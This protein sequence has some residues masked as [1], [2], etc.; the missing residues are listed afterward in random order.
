MTFSRAVRQ[1]MKWNRWKMRP[2]AS[3]LGRQLQGERLGPGGVDRGGAARIPPDLRRPLLAGHRGHEPDADGGGGRVVL[4][5]AARRVGERLPGLE[6]VRPQPL[7][8][9]DRR[10]AVG[11]GLPLRL[12][13]D[14]E[15]EAPPPLLGIA[16]LG[17]SL[18]NLGLATLSLVAAVGRVGV[19]RELDR[20]AGDLLG[21]PRPDLD[22]AR[23]IVVPR[24]VD[25]PI[26][27]GRRRST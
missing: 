17:E 1:L 27:P 19:G 24:L 9:R 6:T 2:M 4:V 25:L 11:L 22:P 23:G 16:A 7:D 14:D 20:L 8:G 12:D 10:G 18:D 3:R 5:A 21:V 15:V 13:V 26:W